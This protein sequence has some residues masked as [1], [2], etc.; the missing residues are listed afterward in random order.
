MVTQLKSS[1]PGKEVNQPKVVAKKAVCR[2]EPRV[3]ILERPKV[4]EIPYK[5]GNKKVPRKPK[6]R[7][8]EWAKFGQNPGVPLTKV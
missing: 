3:P 5:K 2:Q 6:V 7:E 1:F 8:K 4:T